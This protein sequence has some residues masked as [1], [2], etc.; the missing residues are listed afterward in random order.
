MISPVT[1]LPAITDPVHIDGTTQP[2][3][4][5]RFG[6]PVIVLDGQNALAAGLRVLG[7]NAEEC[8]IE[9]LRIVRFDDRHGGQFRHSGCRARR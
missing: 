6:D 7:T 3:F 9:A 1:L 2:G 4:N 8:T 5:P